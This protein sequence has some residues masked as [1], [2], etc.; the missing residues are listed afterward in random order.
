MIIEI[1]ALALMINT[2]QVANSC[3]GLSVTN[4]FLGLSNQ[5]TSLDY[6]KPVDGHPS[7]FQ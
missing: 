1:K 4:H 6:V 2:S 3:V 7:A 5:Q